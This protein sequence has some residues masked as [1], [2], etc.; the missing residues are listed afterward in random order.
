V[1]V[2]SRSRLRKTRENHAILS[3][4]ASDRIELEVQD[5]KFK[6]N[7]NSIGSLAGFQLEVTVTVQELD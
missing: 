5:F 7:L 6:F 4:K 1:T 3:L 2:T